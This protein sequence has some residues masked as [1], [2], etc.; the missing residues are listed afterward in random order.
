LREFIKGKLQVPWNKVQI[1]RGY[2][3]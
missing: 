2:K 3:I 1:I